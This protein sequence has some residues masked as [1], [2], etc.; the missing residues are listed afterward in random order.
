MRLKQ[1]SARVLADKERFT[2]LQGIYMYT[3]TVGIL[4]YRITQSRCYV[5]LDVIHCLLAKLLWAETFR[6]LACA[7]AY[8]HALDAFPI[9]RRY[10]I[11]SRFL[12]GYVGQ[13]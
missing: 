6:K 12:R 7:R 8:T 2:I 4:R 3:E 13:M 9:L 1:T 11:L 10:F 5:I